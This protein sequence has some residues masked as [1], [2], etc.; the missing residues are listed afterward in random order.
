MERFQLHFSNLEM[1]FSL[2]NGECNLAEINLKDSGVPVDNEKDTADEK[3]ESIGKKQM[4]NRTQ[5]SH[6]FIPI[7]L[8]SFL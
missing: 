2:E 4:K 6:N 8:L 3:D 7:L 1:I 5:A